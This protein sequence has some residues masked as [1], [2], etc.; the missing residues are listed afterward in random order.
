MTMQRKITGDKIAYRPMIEAKLSADERDAV[1]RRQ[2]RE[3]RVLRLAREQLRFAARHNTGGQPAGARWYCVQV[4][5]G[6]DFTVEKLLSDCDVEVLSPR[7]TVK[8]VRRGKKFEVQRPCFSGYV[9]ARFVGSAEAFE[10]VRK[11][12]H[13]FG[14]VAGR[15]GYMT[16]EDKDVKRFQSLTTDAI[17][18]MPVDRS[19]GEKDRVKV[20][21]GLFAGKA[22]VVFAV[23]WSREPKARVMVDYDGNLI[24]VKDMPLAFLQKL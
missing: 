3:G 23:K 12:R 4:A 9:L 13:V 14:I 7:E 6:Q 8:I 19:I 18:R 1:Y 17:S 15:N 21:D 22:A 2:Q 24:Q 20:V 11:Q 10:G 16:V 5:G